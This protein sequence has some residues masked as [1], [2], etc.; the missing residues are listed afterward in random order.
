MSIAVLLGLSSGLCW[1]T[2]DFLGGLQSRRLPT[3]AVVLWS[4][5][6]GGAALFAVLAALRETAPVEAIFWGVV[7][8]LFGA[9][10][11]VQFYHALAIGT[12]SIVAPITASG[13]LVPVVAA[14]L[15][16][17]IPTPLAISG[18][19]TALVGGVFASLPEK[20]CASSPARADLVLGLSLGAALCFG[21]FYV[22]V[23]RGSAVV[24]ASPLW[25]IGGTR[26]GSLVTLLFVG[27]VTRQ[28][29]PWPGA[30][31]PAVGVVG[32]LDTLANVLFAY[33]S[34]WGNLGVVSVLGS[35]YPVAT[36]LLARAV[37]A[38]RLTWLQT[39]GVVLALA[40]VVLMAAGRA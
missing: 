39:I 3:L 29:L 32:V 36:V 20:K 28:S 35:L 34:I 26:L 7:S 11:L 12:M 22:F 25:V 38:E 10:A 24:G 40:G 13:A 30:Y 1:G 5:V 9:I 27:M 33:A 18:I 17:E 15:L 37:L 19:A 31:A 23:D 16:G 2:A 8:G 4:Q 21:L 14:L 6:A